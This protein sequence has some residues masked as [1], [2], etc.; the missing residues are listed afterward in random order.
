MSTTT[1]K[2]TKKKTA[3]AGAVKTEKKKLSVMDYVRKFQKK[4][5]F[6]IAKE[7]EDLVYGSN[8]MVKLMQEK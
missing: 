6:T 4:P 3:L 2:T 7:D 1:K 5:L 8:M